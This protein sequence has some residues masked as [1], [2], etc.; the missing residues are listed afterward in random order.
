[1]EGFLT[2]RM[3][4]LHDVDKPASPLLSPFWR[5]HPD[6]RVGGYAGWGAYALNYAIP[7]VRE[8]YFRI[9]EELCA[10]YPL[11]GLEMDFMRFPYYFPYQEGRMAAYADTMTAFVQRVRE[12]T[13]AKGK[14]RGRP[15]LL[16]VRI[17]S[18]LKGC[19][20]VGI[21]PARWS[22]MGLVD[23]LTAAPFL[24]TEPE[25]P[26][27]EF[28]QVC[29]TVPVY[30]ALEYTMG[31]R[32]MVRE[33]TRAAAA[34]HFAAGA[35]GIYLFNYFIAW[36]EVIGI[37]P[38]LGFLRELLW[39][40]SLAGKDKLYTLCAAK[41]PVPNVSL[42]APLPVQVKAGEKVELV[43]HVVEPRRPRSVV[44]RIESDA[45]LTPGELNVVFN[46]SRIEGGRRPSHPQIFPRKIPHPL[47]PVEAAVEYV[48][49]P[50]LLESR[51]VIALSPAKD[52]RVDWIYLGVIGGGRR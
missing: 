29:G 23:F 34:R 50:G 32:M 2:C 24:S 49:D 9:L 48:I 13:E 51:N 43:V 7:A 46:G 45:S 3:N 52:L 11:D 35:D 47:T 16:A 40:D 38:D 20:Y 30:A 5:E 26:V 33:E 39:P 4:E 6:Y 19:T 21:D 17:P 10:R 15:I 42:T 22:R 25:M 1:M 37:A 44:L 36:D 18:S 27:Q 28:K 41:Y 14:Q 31:A 8:Y 12:M